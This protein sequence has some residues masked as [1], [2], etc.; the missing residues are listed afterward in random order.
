MPMLDVGQGHTMYYETHGNP[1]GRPIVIL[2]GGPGGGIMPQAK[3]LFNLKKWFVIQYDQRGCGKSTPRLELKN[4]TTWHLV[5]DI[6]TLRKHLELDAWALYGGS[7]GTSLALAYASKHLD[8]VTAFVLRGICLFTEEENK[9]MFEKGHASEVFPKAWSDVT[10]MLR[11]DTRKLI[12][13]Y[14][15]LLKSK[16]T[17]KAASRA[18]SKYEHNL[19]YLVPQPFK[20]DQKSDEESALLE[21]YYYKHNAWLTP[22]LLLE[23]ARKITVPVLLVHGR[24][25]MVCPASSAIQLKEAIPQAKLFLIPNAGHSTLEPGIRKTLKKEINRLVA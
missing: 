25:D 10:Q 23:T 11:K 4:N 8:R 13:P 6:E 22:E 18:W 20:A 5:E 7:W 12:G 16:K 14:T 17:R 9:W 24:Y 3:S 21:A 2:H 19:S 15:K 1:K